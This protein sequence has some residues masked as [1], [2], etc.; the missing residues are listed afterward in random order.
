MNINETTKSCMILIKVVKMITV[1]SQTHHLISSVQ[2]SKKNSI[3][4]DYYCQAKKYYRHKKT[5]QSTIPKLILSKTF[6]I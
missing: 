5:L 6:R 3:L 4:R 1:P 2:S